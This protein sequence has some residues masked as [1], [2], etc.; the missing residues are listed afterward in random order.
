MKTTVFSIFLIVVGGTQLADKELIDHPGQITADLMTFNSST[1][2]EEVQKILDGKCVSCHSGPAPAKGLELD[3]WKHILS[4]S[5]HGEAVIPFDAASSCAYEITTTLVGGPHPLELGEP[6]L[7]D[8]ETSVLSNWIAEGATS[9]EGAVAFADAKKLLYVANQGDA[10]IS[11]IDMETNVVIRTVDLKELGFSENSQPHHIAVEPDGSYWYV[12]LIGDNTIIKFNRSNN[13]IGR[14]NFERPGLLA[15]D[16]NSDKLYAGRSMAAVSPPQTIGVI[17]RNT[18]EFEEMGVFFPRPHALAVEP[19]SG[20]VYTASLAVN[21][22]ATLY[23]EDENIELTTLDGNRMHTLVQ[24]SI[25]PDG[26]RMAGTTELSSSIFLFDL[27]EG[28]TSNP[29]DTVLTDAAPWHPSFT[30]DGRWI[31]AGNNGANT[32]SVIDTDSR[33][34]A[35]TITGNGLAQPHGS[36]VSP[37]G[38]YVYI[39]NRN[40]ETPAMQMGGSSRAHM[41]GYQSR[42]DLG[43]NSSIGTVVVIDTGSHSIVKVIEI[44]KYGSGLGAARSN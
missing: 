29:S 19:K 35:K 32:V 40:L 5:E 26:Q 2:Y 25:S 7:T 18:M 31:Y 41:E 8:E 14:L 21:Q 23:P 20:A 13:L 34:L 22:I 43:D 30:P 42:Y 44:E 12:S 28:V 38:R 17:D 24:F 6:V 11:V 36:A 27:N 4:G 9:P 33:T 10:L 37:D 16:P 15:L 39:S 1:G 3:S